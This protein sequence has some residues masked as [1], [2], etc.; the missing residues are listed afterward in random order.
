M[1][2]ITMF[3]IK[4][5]VGKT[6]STLNIGAILANQNKKVL[7]VD[8]DPQ[9]NITMAFKQYD[10]DDLSIS[11]LLLYK[12]KNPEIVIKNTDYKNI[13]IIPSNINLIPTE[14]EILRDIT[15]LQQGRLKKVLSLLEDKYDYCLIDCPTYPNMLTINALAASDMVMVPIK[16]DKYSLD[17][18]EYLTDYIENIRYEFNPNLKFGGCFITMYSSTN[19]NKQT[20]E[21]L[22]EMLGD[23]L[24][25]TVIRQNIV[26][27][28]STFT[29]KPLIDYKKKSNATI[30][31]IELVK[32]AFNE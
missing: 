12:E 7:I 21:A 15:T 18:L 17:G 11:D 24:Y 2:K 25:N 16:I 19:V 26:V 10:I 29:Q 22:S 31:Y 14:N 6:T 9:A 30:D 5:G 1:K 8:L 4:G 3:N 23:L 32:E 28:E 27:V 13:D 20:K